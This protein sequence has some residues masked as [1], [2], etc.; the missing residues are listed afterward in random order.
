MPYSQSVIT[1]LLILHF[2][3]AIPAGGYCSSIDEMMDSIK[4][5]ISLPSLQDS[6]PDQVDACEASAKKA[7]ELKVLESSIPGKKE[8]AA[9]CETARSAAYYAE[10]SALEEKKKF[11]ATHP[12]FAAAP[13]YASYFGMDEKK[14]AIIAHLDQ[15]AS[16]CANIISMLSSEGSTGAWDCSRFAEK[17]VRAGCSST[18]QKAFGVVNGV[19]SK[20]SKLARDLKQCIVVNKVP[21]SCRALVRLTDNCAITGRSLWGG[22]SMPSAVFDS[23]RIDKSLLDSGGD[24]C[25]MKKKEYLALIDD[26]ERSKLSAGDTL[27]DKPGTQALKAE[28]AGIDGKYETAVLRNRQAS[29][30]AE[31]ARGELSVMEDRRKELLSSIKTDNVKCSQQK[32]AAVITPIGRPAEGYKITGSPRMPV[33][34]AKAKPAGGEWTYRVSWSYHRV[35]CNYPPDLSV[36]TSG[37]SFN[38]AVYNDK[39][40]GGNVLLTYTA[41]CSGKVSAVYEDTITGDEPD[42]KAQVQEEI[43]AQVKKYPILDA[44]ADF[45]ILKEIVCNESEYHQFSPSGSG[46]PYTANEMDIGLFQ[47]RTTPTVEDHCD[48]AWNW[49][50]NVYRGVNIYVQ[51]MKGA[52]NHHKS[53]VDKRY[54]DNTDLQKCIS[55]KVKKFINL[56]GRNIAD[57]AALDAAVSVVSQTIYSKTKIDDKVLI[58]LRKI[59]DEKAIIELMA[60]KKSLE[61]IPP[62]LTTAPDGP[63]RTVSEIQGE[64]IRRYNGGREH[65]FE[66]DRALYETCGGYWKI[67][68]KT[69]AEN[70]KYVKDVLSRDGNCVKKGN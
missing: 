9:E 19:L 18:K 16:I 69:K 56:K 33:I 60:L 63:N 28:F 67:Q 65:K 35:I 47:V 66:V 7:D 10:Q 40:F 70:M 48:A 57:E 38:G 4:R 25:A 59:L 41:D 51:K 64:A 2:L 14:N 30:R 17:S 6:L 27:P 29:A 55:D 11:L 37:D 31:T 44:A 22:V 61:A 50:H 20:A 34:T 49:R 23:Y 3:L 13:K 21:G 32:C 53:E 45:E 43:L 52:Q 46:L 39:I 42:N 26:Y 1:R 5:K 12:E 58:T 62:A 54:G 68:P 24:I 36:K 15:D 8:F